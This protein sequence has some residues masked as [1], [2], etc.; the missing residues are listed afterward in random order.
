MT[1]DDLMKNQHCLFSKSLSLET[2]TRD[3]I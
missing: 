3:L 1:Q 2:P